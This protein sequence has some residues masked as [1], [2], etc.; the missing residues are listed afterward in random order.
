MVNNEYILCEPYFVRSVEN[1]M[2]M[3][4]IPRKEKQFQE[5]SYV[6]LYIYM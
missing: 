6:L 4:H 5:S 3:I 1:N 2:I